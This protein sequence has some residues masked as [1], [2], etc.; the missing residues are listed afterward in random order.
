MQRASERLVRVTACSISVASLTRLTAFMSLVQQGV[1]SSE[2]RPVMHSLIPAY[3]ELHRQGRFPGTSIGPY[4]EHIAE[5]VRES[6]AQTLLDYGC[7]AG[8]QYTKSAGTRRGA[9][10]R[11][12]T[13]QR[14]QNS[15]VLPCGQFDGVIC[16]DVL[17]HVPEDELDEVIADLVRL[18]R[19]WCFVSVCCRPAKPNKNLPGGINAHVTIRPQAW[20]LDRLF[21]AFQGSHRQRC[22]WRSRRDGLLTW[23]RS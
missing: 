17:E 13:I 10:C 21:A 3:R 8:E 23:S 5:L 6:G 2:I 19:L 12:S 16:T 22:T 9:S 1:L 11:R 14:C 15:R 4:V 18:S 20:W 7:G